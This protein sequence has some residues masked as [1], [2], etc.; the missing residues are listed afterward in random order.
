MVYGVVLVSTVLLSQFDLKTNH[1]VIFGII[2]LTARS[3]MY[4]NFAFLYVI[5][6]N[7]FPTHFLS[8]SLGICNIFSRTLTLFAPMLAEM[9]DLTIPMYS[10]ILFSFSGCLFTFLL[11]TPE[12]Q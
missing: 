6:T 5:N 8:T 1:V 10:L 9:E 7:L 2:L 11:K 3:G 4:L 12:S